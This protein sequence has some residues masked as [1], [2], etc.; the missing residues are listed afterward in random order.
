MR[1]SVIGVLLALAL[2][3]SAMAAA[4][5]GVVLHLAGRTVYIPAA[6]LTYDVSS[7]T[8]TVR[9]S[10]GSRKVTHQGISLAALFATVGAN[11]SDYKFVQ[12]RRPDDSYAFVTS[13]DAPIF[14]VRSDVTH[15]LRPVRNKTDENAPDVFGS[16][17]G[18][19]IVVTARTGNPITVTVAADPTQAN[20]KQNVSFSGTASGQK[21]GEKLTYTWHFGDGGQA[22]GATAQ[23]AYD[24]PGGYNV[25]VIVTGSDDSAGSSDAVRVTVGKPQTGTTGGGG[26]A[27]GST[28]GGGSTTPSPPPAVNTPQTPPAPLTSIPKTEGQ[29]G[30]TSVS[31]ILLASS[32]PVPGGSL[33]SRGTPAL[34]KT[35]S[36]PNRELPLAGGAAV[37]LLAI[38]AF[39]E[40]G[41]RIRIPRIP[42]PWPH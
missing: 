31:G 32:N 35:G 14:W 24:S 7:Q 42:K 29:P 12:I 20:T 41:R 34:A 2:P 6:K 11:L 38:G 21:T 22:S 25:F 13:K 5:S 40:S 39:L 4:Q 37:L 18:K 36:T 3:S 30:G 15:F 16:L 28:G 8:Y 23:H 33:L 26:T 9:G 10:K 1:A 17:T 27:G 19:P